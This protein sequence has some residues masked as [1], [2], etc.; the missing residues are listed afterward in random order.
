MRRERTKK[1]NE[2]DSA[3]LRVLTSCPLVRTL[4]KYMFLWSGCIKE[5]GIEV[6]QLRRTGSS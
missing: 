2:L 4:L 6:R 1:W 3:A 5:S